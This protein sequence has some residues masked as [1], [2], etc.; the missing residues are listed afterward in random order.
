MLYA[1]LITS[2]FA[3]S[4][5]SG[6]LGMA[7]GMILMAI[8]VATLPVASAMILHGA[9]QFTANAS[10][11]WFLRSHIQWGI[12]PWYAVGAFTVLGAFSIL[13]LVPEAGVILLLIGL[14]SLSARF[15]GRLA[16]LDIT[17]PL[18]ATMCGAI[19]TA[20]QL[21][22]GA[23]GPILD[24]FYLSSPL[25]RHA[26]VANK[27][28]TQAF[29]HTLKIGYYGIIAGVGA[30]LSP[31]LIAGAMLAAVAGTRVGTSLLDRFNDEG[32]KRWSGHAI[33]VIAVYCVVQGASLI[34]GGT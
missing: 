24:V 33:T 30:D 20:A 13:S 7:G 14:L 12:L 17:R 16:R 8:L 11:A 2:V 3:T 34:A 15:S 31:A 21:L 29:G 22:A 28:L 1:L 5:L 27:A 26:I 32:F 25:S 19:V 4:V 23:S 18:T 6:V 10:R 9:A